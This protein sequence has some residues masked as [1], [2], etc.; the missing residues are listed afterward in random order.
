MF[1]CGL[2]GKKSKPGE[3]ATQVVTKTRDKKYETKVRVKEEKP[4]PFLPKRMEDA[5][6]FG[7]EIVEEVKACPSCASKVPTK[8][9]KRGNLIP[10]AV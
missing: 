2:C 8:L 4:N 10:I 1:T 3:S 7:T 9:S 5:I 6:R